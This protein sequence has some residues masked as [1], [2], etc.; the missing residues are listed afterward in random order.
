MRM[1]YCVFLCDESLLMCLPNNIIN[2][3]CTYTSG[4]LTQSIISLAD[5]TPGFRWWNINLF[6]KYLYLATCTSV[7]FVLC[8]PDSAYTYTIFKIT[9]FV[10]CHFC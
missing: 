7:K 8:Q 5:I 4:I 3:I 10:Y 2:C 6:I 9:K 1:C